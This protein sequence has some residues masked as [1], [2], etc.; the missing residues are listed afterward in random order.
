MVALSGIMARE[1]IWRI[2]AAGT[3]AGCHSKYAPPDDRATRSWRATEKES[4]FMLTFIL[5]R[6]LLATLTIWALSILSFFIIQLPPGDYVDTYIIELMTGGYESGDSGGGVTDALEKTLRAQYGLDKPMYVQYAKWAWRVLHGDFGQSL[7]FEKPVAEV[8]RGRLFMTIILAGT[9]ALFAWGISIPIGIYS[10]VRQ[11][12]VEDYAIT[13]IGFMGLAVPDFL[14]A[15]WLLWITFVY[16]PDLGIGGL[17]SPEYV[18]APWSVDRF[19]DFISHLWIAAFVVGTAGTAAL[20]RVMRANLLDELNKPYV[21]TAR[22]KGMPE[23][24]LILKYPVRL[25][26]NP[27]VSTLGYLLPVLMSGS[28][29]VSVVLSLPTEGP[30]L[31]RALLAEDLFVS[32]AIV[33]LLGT[34]TVIGT[35]LSD[36]LL[37][38]L[39]PRIRVTTS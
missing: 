37:G 2:T 5:R 10:A 39:D 18:N 13:F 21:V 38:I 25:A 4:P 27:L 22:A 15:L 17:F 6:A 31:L 35:L 32:A 11:H 30:L 23:W 8:V 9:T 24:K 19:I 3:G 33:M 20:I 26:L 7:E 16:F 36:I 34:L 14:L 29:I 1:T 28:V 12:S